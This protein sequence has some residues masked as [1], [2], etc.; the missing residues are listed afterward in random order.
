MCLGC[1][2]S[3]IIITYCNVYEVIDLITD[4]ADPAPGGGVE[5]LLVPEPVD[6]AGGGHVPAEHAGQ[7]EGGPLL[8]VHRGPGLDLAHGIWNRWDDPI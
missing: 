5:K 6:V 8:H 2:N 3:Q 1:Q 4:D 7:V